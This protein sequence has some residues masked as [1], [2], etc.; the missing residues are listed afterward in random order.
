M[1]GRGG[2]R[3]ED[4]VALAVSLVEGEIAAMSS[5]S[6]NLKDALQAFRRENEHPAARVDS[7]G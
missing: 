3:D 7:E 5:L 1:A 4:A 2:L 6:R